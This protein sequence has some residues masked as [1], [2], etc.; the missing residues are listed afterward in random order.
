[1]SS[2][3][4]Q[5]SAIVILVLCL[6]GGVFVLLRHGPDPNE[7]PNMEVNYTPP[8]PA[9]TERTMDPNRGATLF[10]PAG[11]WPTVPASND[12]SPNEPNAM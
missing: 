12:V 1:M 7:N 8:V 9:A 11:Q 3:H 6:L 4:Y 2:K 10:I 5:Y